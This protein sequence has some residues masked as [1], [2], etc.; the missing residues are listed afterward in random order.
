MSHSP[1]GVATTIRGPGI[2]TIRS[3]MA[4]RGHGAG[5]ALSGVGGRRGAGTGVGAGAVRLGRGAGTGAGVPV[6]VALPGG[7]AVPD[8]AGVPVADGRGRVPEAIRLTVA[9]RQVFATVTQVS[10]PTVPLQAAALTQMEI[11]AITVTVIS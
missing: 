1:A 11:T 4:R 9:V 6:G 10:A 8:G 3:G 5:A 7:G 2:I